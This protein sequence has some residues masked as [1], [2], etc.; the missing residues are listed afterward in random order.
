[1][2]Y[3]KKDYLFKGVA[4][5][6]S[7]IV[8][9]SVVSNSTVDEEVKIALK[10]LPNVMICVS[11]EQLTSGSSSVSGTIANYDGFLANKM[12]L[13][14]KTE[15]SMDLTGGIFTCSV[16]GYYTINFS[17]YAGLNNMEYV[18]IYIKHNG[19]RVKESF[20]HQQTQLS[21]GYARV[22]QSRTVVSYKLQRQ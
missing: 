10:K 19:V 18:Q 1:M 20:S 11:K 4:R 5:S 22:Q 6:N 12:T 16:P 3:L 8:S 17:S 21:T 13:L 7:E 2:E 9:P 15:S 14:G